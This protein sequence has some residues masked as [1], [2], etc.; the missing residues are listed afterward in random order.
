V[1]FLEVPA[2]AK[3]PGFDKEKIPRSKRIFVENFVDFFWKV[4]KKN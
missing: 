1:P 3:A 2:Q 4:S